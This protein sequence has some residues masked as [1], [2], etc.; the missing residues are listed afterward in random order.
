MPSCKK[1]NDTG[2]IETGNNDLPCE[3]PAGDKALFNRAGEGQISGAE[4]KRLHA[5]PQPP[6]AL[7]NRKEFGHQFV[8]LKRPG[9]WC[10]TSGQSVMVVPP[11]DV[12]SR[13]P[14]LCIVPGQI[15]VEEFIGHQAEQRAFSV[16]EAYT[17]QLAAA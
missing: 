14:W 7:G 11:S 9:C 15:R 3:C 10:S 8:W 1:C 2:V 12:G 5:L 17:R 16:A 4:I 13:E 6:T